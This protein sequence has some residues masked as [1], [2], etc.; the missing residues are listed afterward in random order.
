MKKKLLLRKCNEKS[1]TT[2]PVELQ[3]K[4]HK[5]NFRFSQT[6]PSTGYLLF[7][8]ARAFWIVFVILKFRKHNCNIN[9]FK[10]VI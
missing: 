7:N 3:S 1:P 6:I 2:N 5:S 4:Q 8:I 10:N 9:V